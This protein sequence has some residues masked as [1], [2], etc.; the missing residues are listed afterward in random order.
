MNV[1]TIKL[2]L[3]YSRQIHLQGQSGIENV[4]KTMEIGAE[5]EI[6]P[7]DNWVDEHE[8]LY[9]T[10]SNQLKALWNKGL[11]QTEKDKEDS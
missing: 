3:R 5:A 4:H 11:V 2:S 10:L 9:N 6:L 1:K 7:G 8:K